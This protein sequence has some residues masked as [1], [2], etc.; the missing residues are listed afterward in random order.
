[1]VDP[2]ELEDAFLRFTKN[3]SH[4]IPDGFVQIDLQLLQG[5]DLLHSDIGEGDAEEDSLTYY[6]HVIESDDKLTL[7]NEEFVVWIIPDG[8]HATTYALIARYDVG[9]LQ[10]EMGF[11]AAGVYNSSE[12]VLKVL[13]QFLLEIKENDALIEEMKT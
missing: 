4:W 13:E 1:M 2:H 3:L 7:F 10:L 12:L 9:I 5:L 8:D 11:A 6:F